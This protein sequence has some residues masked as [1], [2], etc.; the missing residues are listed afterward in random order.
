MG[1]IYKYVNTNN[2]IEYIGKTTRPIKERII[3]H[4][5]HPFLI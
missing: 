3:E 5:S 1:Y 2:E 4:Q